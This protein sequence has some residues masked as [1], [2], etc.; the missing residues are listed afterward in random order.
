MFTSYFKSIFDFTML[1]YEINKLKKLKWDNEKEFK[2]RKDCMI[3]SIW[4]CTHVSSERIISFNKIHFHCPFFISSLWSNIEPVNTYDYYISWLD[5]SKVILKGCFYDLFSRN[6]ILTYLLQWLFRLMLFIICY[7]IKK[8]IS[9]WI[10]W[11][12]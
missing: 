7:S 1:Y 10:D 12:F 6:K 5:K 8:I 3:K 11:F 4:W 9:N 2:D